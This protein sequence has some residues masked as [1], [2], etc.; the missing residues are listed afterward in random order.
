VTDK[1]YAT[2]QMQAYRDRW[3][4][5]CEVSG[6]IRKLCPEFKEHERRYMLPGYDVHHIFGRRSRQSHAWC[7]LIVVSKAA[8]DWGHRGTQPAFNV[9]LAFEAC[10]LSVKHRQQIAM[11]MGPFIDRETEQHR[12]HWDVEQYDAIR[13][14][15]TSYYTMRDRCEYLESVLE[16]SPFAG[17][18]KKLVENI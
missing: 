18:A 9:G 2:Q 6:V 1:A 17:L 3:Q 5:A 10:C 7:N 13:R 11:T 15:G 16:D 14:A 8:H 12:Q 4:G